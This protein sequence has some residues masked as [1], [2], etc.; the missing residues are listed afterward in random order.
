VSVIKV[1]GVVVKLFPQYKGGEEKAAKL[2]PAAKN[3]G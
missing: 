1:R 3:E 2:L